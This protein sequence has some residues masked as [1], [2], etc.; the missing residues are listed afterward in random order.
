MNT[1]QTGQGAPNPLEQLKDIHLP[2][3]ISSWPPA[4][5]WWLVTIII[6]VTLTSAITLLY[7]YWQKTSYKRQAI[8]KLKDIQLKNQTDDEVIN[9]LAELLR[10]TAIAANMPSARNLHGEQWQALLQ[11]NMPEKTAQL[12]AIGRYKKQMASDIET[13]Q[14]Y[15]DVLHWIKKHRNEET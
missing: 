4:M 14:L 7:L 10:Q 6:I 15:T 12:F 8:K 2:D 3:A 11:K 5:G 1:A 13:P 9:T